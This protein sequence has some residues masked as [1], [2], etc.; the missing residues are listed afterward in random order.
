MGKRETLY[1]YPLKKENKMEVA[2]DLFLSIVGAGLGMGF[3]IIIIGGVSF[4]LAK[5]FGLVK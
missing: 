2:K 5:L 1:L 4:L 3:V